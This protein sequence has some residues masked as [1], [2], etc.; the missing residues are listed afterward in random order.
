MVIEK[1]NKYKKQFEKDQQTILNPFDNL[2]RKAYWITFPMKMIMTF[3][4]IFS[5]NK[6]MKPTRIVFTKL[7]KQNSLFNKIK[8]KK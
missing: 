6:S 8:E 7:K 1:H 3:S 2:Y 5:P 4:V